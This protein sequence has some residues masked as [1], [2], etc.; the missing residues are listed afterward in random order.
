M[1]KTT[2]TLF[3]ILIVIST[4]IK[5]V[6]Q[7]GV[8]YRTHLHDYVVEYSIKA[9]A[10]SITLIGYGYQGGKYIYTNRREILD[11]MGRPFIYESPTLVY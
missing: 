5:G 1:T 3:A 8:F 2:F 4:L 7:S 10:L 6:Y 9:L 11:N